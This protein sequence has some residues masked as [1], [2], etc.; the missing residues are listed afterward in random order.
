MAYAKKC[1]YR[2][3]A[4]YPEFIFRDGE[5]HDMVH[6]VVTLKE[7]LPLWKEFEIKMKGETND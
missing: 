1:G 5:Y 7:W 6:F 3:I 2:E 4:R